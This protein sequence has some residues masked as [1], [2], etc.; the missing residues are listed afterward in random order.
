MNTTDLA[1]RLAADGKLT[2]AQAREAVDTLLGA[3]RE[4]LV[5]GHEVNLPGFG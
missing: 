5:L 1:E 2:K 4:A 3:V